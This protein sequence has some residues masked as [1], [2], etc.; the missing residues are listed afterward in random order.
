[1]STSRRYEHAES[2][3]EIALAPTLSTAAGV[4]ATAAAATTTATTASNSEGRVLTQ[5]EEIALAKLHSRAMESKDLAEASKTYA[6]REPKATLPQGPRCALEEDDSAEEAPASSGATSQKTNKSKTKQKKKKKKKKKKEKKHVTQYEA[7]VK[8]WGNM[9]IALPSLG[10]S[11][12]RKDYYER[13]RGS[14]RGRGEGGGKGGPNEKTT[15]IT[16]TMPEPFALKHTADR[17]EKANLRK[18][19]S[20]IE[21]FRALWH[22]SGKAGVVVEGAGSGVAVGSN[23]VF[24][25]LAQL[26]DTC[27]VLDTDR[28]TAK[29]WFE[30]LVKEKKERG[31]YGD[32]EQGVQK[33][34]MKKKEGGKGWFGVKVK[35][36]KGSVVR[37]E[38]VISKYAN[39]PGMMREGRQD[40]SNQAARSTWAKRVRDTMGLTK[41]RKS[42]EKRL[43]AQK[44][45]HDNEQLVDEGIASTMTGGKGENEGGRKRSGGWRVTQSLSFNFLT[46]KRAKEKDFRRTLQLAQELRLLDF[47]G[48]GLLSLQDLL[49]GCNGVSN[50][51]GGGRSGG[52]G[53]ATGTGSGTGGS[54]DMDVVSAKNMFEEVVRRGK[55]GNNRS[56]DTDK[57]NSIDSCNSSSSSSSSSHGQPLVA[58]ED[59]VA[60]FL[61]LQPLLAQQAK[62][63]K[64][65]T[66]VESM[67]LYNKNLRT[68]GNAELVAAHNTYDQ[69]KTTTTNRDDWDGNDGDG[70]GRSSSSS[71]TGYGVVSP[72]KP[73]EFA[74]AS[75]E[76]QAKRNAEGY[77]PARHSQTAE[78]C[79]HPH[80]SVGVEDINDYNLNGSKYTTQVLLAERGFFKARQENGHLSTE[81]Q[82][83]ELSSS[84]PNKMPQPAT[85]Y[86]WGISA[87]EV[88]KTDL[89][90]RADMEKVRC[91]LDLT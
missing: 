2:R 20:A 77:T 79:E 44:S 72:T 1:L 12:A 61:E 64:T 28:S 37:L 74:F 85:K 52:G 75:D 38:D 18:Q 49:K 25:S 57:K 4:D 87:A 91:G 89:N 9:R 48:D 76:L 3:H 78:P 6:L 56:S 32:E 10:L 5:K 15:A 22:T 41:E 17:A 54:I 27:E 40:L 70:G 45:K 39:K 19:E 13:T 80:C 90:L 65:V 50:N 7:M 53:I 14:R 29:S 33:K 88:A 83:F 46:S 11:Q 82:E 81:V 43:A 69:R 30:E 68:L 71:K 66:T 67:A 73:R 26:L 36:G 86:E 62:N 59:L 58:V 21:A 24:L 47:D 51:D 55:K 31:L 23:D 16:T 42:Y 60:K 84:D 35:R 63:A 34:M 8:Y